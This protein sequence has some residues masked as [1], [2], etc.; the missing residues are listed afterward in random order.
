MN[1]PSQE[2]VEERA[3]RLWGRIY[4]YDTLSDVRPIERIVTEL[5]DYAQTIREETITE[6]RKIL[7]FEGVLSMSVEKSL[8]ELLTPT[9]NHTENV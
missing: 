9:T 8:E 2:A 3:K 4:F 6:A 1:N 7:A 5:Q